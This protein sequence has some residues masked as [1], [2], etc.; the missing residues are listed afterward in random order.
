MSETRREKNSL[1]ETS[2]TTECPHRLE[3][4]LAITDVTASATSRYSP[5]SAAPREGVMEFAAM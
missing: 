5:Q 4:R 1:R 3:S 2:E